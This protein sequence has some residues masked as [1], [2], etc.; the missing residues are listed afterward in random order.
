MLQLGMVVLSFNWEINTIEE[1]NANVWKPC[2]LVNID[3]RT[4]NGLRAFIPFTDIHFQRL[5]LS[6]SPPPLLSLSLALSLSAFQTINSENLTDGA[7][8]KPT[9]GSA[10]KTGYNSIN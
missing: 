5:S 3:V 8:L 1:L 2:T 9:C 6:L 10:I 7:A 4:L